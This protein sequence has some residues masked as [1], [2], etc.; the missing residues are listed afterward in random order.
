[1][2]VLVTNNHLLPSIVRVLTPAVLGVNTLARIKGHHLIFRHPLIVARACF[3]RGA[4]AGGGRPGG[5]GRVAAGGH[6]AAGTRATINGKRV[7]GFQLQAG[8]FR[9]D[10]LLNSGGGRSGGICFL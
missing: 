9:P 4:T 7:A 10:V 8:K 6:R 2:V 1:M 3:G 5:T